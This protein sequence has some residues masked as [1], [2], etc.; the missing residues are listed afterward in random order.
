M[1][2]SNL[3]VVD[4]SGCGYPVDFVINQPTPQKKIQLLDFEGVQIINF[5]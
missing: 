4:G 3:C 2:N 5:L 1:M